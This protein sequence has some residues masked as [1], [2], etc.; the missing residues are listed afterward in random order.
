M[1]YLLP[2]LLLTGCAMSQPM[3]MPDGSQGYNISCDG[4]MNS[5][6]NCFQKAG[7]LCGARGYDIITREGEIIPYGVSGGAFQ[8]DRYAA[9]GGYVS[10]NG[11]FV[12]RS[13]MIRCK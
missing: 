10:Q 3:Y 1:R 8:A 13:L 7:Q 11:A 12:N 9:N 4:S 5:M 6:G 2:A